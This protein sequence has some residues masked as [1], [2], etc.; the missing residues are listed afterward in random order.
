[1]NEFDLVSRERRGVAVF[2][3]NPSTKYQDVLEWAKQDFKLSETPSTSALCMWLKPETKKSSLDFLMH[4][5]LPAGNI[6]EAFK[7]QH[8]E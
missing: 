4:L 1:M 6:G 7:G 3:Q 8:P 5:V 2:S